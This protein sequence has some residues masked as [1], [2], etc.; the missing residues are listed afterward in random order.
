[1]TLAEFTLDAGD[2]QSYYDISLVDGYNLPLAIVLVPHGNSSLDDIPPN[3]TNPSCEGTGSMLAPSCHSRQR[4]P[5]V[6]LISGVL[7]IFKSTF[8]PLLETTCILT[9]TATFNDLRL[10]LATQLVPNTTLTSTVAWANTTDR[11]NAVPTTTP[12]QLR[13]PAQMHTAMPT[14]T[15]HLPSSSLLELASKWCFVQAAEVR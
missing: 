10:T 5:Q 4:S 8:Q 9:P 6:M 12:K 11:T 15:S 1:V 3:L 2:G 7:G 14:T 13:P